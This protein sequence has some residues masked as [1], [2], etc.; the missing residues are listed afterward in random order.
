MIRLEVDPGGGG[1]T[2]CIRQDT[3]L[4]QKVLHRDDRYPLPVVVVTDDA[5]D[6]DILAR[7]PFIP[8]HADIDP[9]PPGGADL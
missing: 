1:R 8:R 2:A 6:R 5:A 3:P 9:I 7:R 4:D